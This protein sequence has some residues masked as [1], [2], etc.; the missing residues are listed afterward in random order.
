[1]KKVFLMVRELRKTSKGWVTCLFNF[2]LD[3]EIWLIIFINSRYSI[4]RVYFFTVLERLL[5]L[6]LD[7]RKT[8]PSRQIW[9]NGRLRVKFH[10]PNPTFHLFHFYHFR[11]FV[12]LSV[13]SPRPFLSSEIF[14][15]I[16]REVMSI[17]NLL[18]FELCLRYK[19]LIHFIFRING[20]VTRVSRIL[21]VFK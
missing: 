19:H 5:T 9:R 13:E 17:K 1:M 21:S 16:F 7:S 20:I 6:G 12:V 2:T 15:L 14:V 3:F 4:C 11:I 8:P 10:F 18:N